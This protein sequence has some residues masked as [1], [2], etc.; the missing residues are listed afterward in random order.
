MTEL[1]T[2]VLVGS[3]GLQA[4][5]D[6][7]AD[8]ILIDIPP[9]GQRHHRRGHLHSVPH[10]HTKLKALT[11]KNAPAMESS[12]QETTTPS[13]KMFPS[14]EPKATIL[15]LYVD[16]ERFVEPLKE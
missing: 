3:D 5:P 14:A 16:D 6:A 2:D 11:S 1:L 13:N 12:S 9:G 8:F 10:S 4:K 7:K 15:R